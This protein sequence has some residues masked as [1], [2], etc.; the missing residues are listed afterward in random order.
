MP[1]KAFLQYRTAADGTSLLNVLA[2]ERGSPPLQLKYHSSP[3]GVACSSTAPMPHSNPTTHYFIQHG[4][5]KHCVNLACEVGVCRTATELCLAL[6]LYANPT[7]HPLMVVAADPSPHAAGGF[8]AAPSISCSGAPTQACHA[9]Q[10]GRPLSGHPGQPGGPAA[11]KLLDKHRS[12]KRIN[13]IAKLFK[14]QDKYQL[15]TWQHHVGFTG[16]GPVLSEIDMVY[17]ASTE[18]G[19]RCVEQNGWEH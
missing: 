6:P 7:A 11:M 2:A 19:H 15:R 1:R 5:P 4:V 9:H 13:R 8:R 16:L 14:F 3:Q 12:R 18:T 10:P 17:D